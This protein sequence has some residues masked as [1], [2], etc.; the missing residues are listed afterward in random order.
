MS[1]DVFDF[2]PK[3]ERK[4]GG[5][6]LMVFGFP[7]L[8]IGGF[9]MLTALGLTGVA[10]DDDLPGLVMFLMGAVFSGAGTALMFGRAGI[11]IDRTSSRVTKWWGLLLPIK[12]TE[13]DLSRYDRI[14]VGKEIRR[15]SNSEKTVFPVR[16]A[17]GQGVE[18]LEYDA[19]VDY[20][21]ARRL[22]E[23]LAR[24][25]GLDIEDSM[26]GRTV[27]RR[28]EDLDESVHD[29]IRRTGERIALPATPLEMRA[30]VREEAGATI[31]DLPP[32]GLTLSN[33]APIFP[34]L[35]FTGMVGLF[36]LPEL[37]SAGT[38]P[39]FQLI[40]GGFVGFFFVFLPIVV[41]FGNAIR[42]A[43]RRVTITASRRM[44]RVEIGAG[45]KRKVTEIPGAELEEFVLVSRKEDVNAAIGQAGEERARTTENQRV[46]QQLL[47]PDSMLWKLA[48]MVAKSEIVARSD[49]ETV[50]FGRGLPD[51]EL[52]YLHAV[53][54][55]ALA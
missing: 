32:S 22:S 18:E 29:R 12:V 40:F 15:D 48:R 43:R 17:G 5:G 49:T 26:S 41:V 9:L 7:F 1:N 35:F 6:C 55:R 10:M 31:V 33:I 52:A 37:L 47:A 46:I 36:F 3:M 30:E 13:Y 14:T 42:Q 4:S 23:E 53:L 19:P 51:V 54:L 24:Y 21:A 38:P 27:L 50:R 2:D 39:E 16:L 11:T 34:V 45:R 28:L 25:V 20:P 8:L 44:L